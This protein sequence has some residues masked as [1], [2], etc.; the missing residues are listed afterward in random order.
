M[1][2]THDIDAVVEA[3]ERKSQRAAQRRDFLRVATGFAAGAGGAL[4][5]SACGGG[6]ATSTSTA[7]AQTTG[8]SD[9]DI[10]NFA[11]QLEYLEANFYS[12][13]ANG[14]AISSN[15]MTGTGTQGSV[16][17]GQKAALT[18]P[19]V[20]AYA[21][22]IAQD[23]LKH[24]TFL[25]SALGSA[26]V[27]MPTLDVS[28]TPTSAFSTAAQAAGLIPAGSTFNPYAND[29]SF[30]LGAYIFEDVGVTAYHGAATLLASKTYLS[31]AAG[32]LAVEAYHAAI[33][34]TTLYAMGLMNPPP[35][36]D[37]YKATGA[38]SALRSKLDGTNN[39]DQGIQGANPT[40]S[41]IVDADSNALAY[42]RTTGQV[43]NIVYGNPGVTTMGGFFPK[44]INGPIN[45]SA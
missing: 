33:I 4:A 29:E 12:Y 36:I 37:P 31:A 21:N 34:R 30:L 7:V 32:I 42:A 44:G 3:L 17:A 8:P 2:T 18:N 38:I 26:A 28:A 40:I 27:A 23:E 43:L 16:I 1:D 24:V 14:G 41:N 6:A 15:L 20:I 35:P 19:L 9:A 10:L 39:D 45:T 22:E 5:L 25:R 11:L 13:A